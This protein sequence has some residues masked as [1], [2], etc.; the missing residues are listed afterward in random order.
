MIK[1]L[2]YEDNDLLRE[3]IS[4]MLQ[5]MEGMELLGAFDHANNVEA[6]VKVHRPD[7]ILMDIDMPGRNGIDATRLVKK[8]F[9]EVYILIMTVFDDSDNVLNAI[10]VGASGYLLKKHIANRLF[11]AVEE[12]LEGGAPMSPAV[13][14]LV[15]QSMQRPQQLTDYGLTEREKDIL[16]SLSK[17]NSF[18]LIAA[19]CKISID[20]VRT[21]IKRI[22][23]KL[24][25]HCQTEAVSKAINEGLV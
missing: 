3:S 17:G 6:E 8:L 13:A 25:V 18:K 9:P 7:L 19:D 16:V 2:L 20:T 12:I 15:I 22:Y 23:E 11:D 1:V 24:Q 10:K 4:C 14:K 5:I 21:H